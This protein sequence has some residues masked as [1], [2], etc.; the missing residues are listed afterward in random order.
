MRRRAAASAPPRR[1]VR[2]GRDRPPD[3]PLAAA[4]EPLDQPVRPSRWP[5]TLG[6][7]P[8]AGDHG[9]IP[10][11]SGEITVAARPH[12][13]IRSDRRTSPSDDASDEAAA[14][15]ATA[16]GSTR[17]PPATLWVSSASTAAPSFPFAKHRR[18]RSRGG[19]APRLPIGVVESD[20]VGNLGRRAGPLRRRPRRV[21]E[22]QRRRFAT[23][24]GARLGTP[25]DAS[26][27]PA[28]PARR[29]TRRASGERPAGDPGPHAEEELAAGDVQG[30]AVG[31]AEGAVGDQVL[32]HLDEVEELAR[33][34]RSR[35]CRAGCRASR[36][37]S[38][39]GG[40]PAAT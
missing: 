35:G 34:A 26:T 4:A 10:A 21:P 5:G 18:D 28:S 30:A 29:P 40:G 7:C 23:I 32:G 11:R 25:I 39:G 27:V 13:A 37:H 38:G 15:D 33:A 3:V 31:A 9:A 1:P 6:P 20:P 24:R 2:L 22:N 36:S 16:P 8:A 12:P 17:G 14:T 19:A